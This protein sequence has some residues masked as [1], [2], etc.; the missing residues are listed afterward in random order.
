MHN[1]VFKEMILIPRSV[2]NRGVDATPQVWYG[3]NNTYV[4]SQDKKGKKLKKAPKK[5]DNHKF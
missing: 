2:F 1:F 5:R 3:E 4:S